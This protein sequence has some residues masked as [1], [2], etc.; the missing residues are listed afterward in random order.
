MEQKQNLNKFQ[1]IVTEAHQ[2]K[3]EDYLNCKGRMQVFKGP[4][5]CQRKIDSAKHDL[6][7]ENFKM[8]G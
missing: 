2:Q 7:V 1:D 6:K 3:K 5:A 8:E 4:A